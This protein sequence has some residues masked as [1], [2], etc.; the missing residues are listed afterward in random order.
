M[1]DLF[2]RYMYFIRAKRDNNK[3]TTTESLRKFYER[4]K[5]SILKQ[6]S[7]FDDLK[8]L[9]QFWEDIADQNSKRFSENILRNSLRS[10]MHQIVCGTILYLFI[11]WQIVTKTET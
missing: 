7:T 9:A 4:D 10:T 6:N 3:S 2:A 5:Y 8:D 1:D 11:I